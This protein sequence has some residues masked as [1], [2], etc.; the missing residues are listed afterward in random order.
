MQVEEMTT[1][2]VGSL[3]EEKKSLR[4]LI[5]QGVCTNTFWLASVSGELDLDFDGLRVAGLCF[6]ASLALLPH[7]HSFLGQNLPQ[8]FNQTQ[9]MALRP[10][11]A[12]YAP[13]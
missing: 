13:C 11:P 9:V 5:N 6:A 2:W 3:A 7:L 1:Q 10:G 8:S 4:G 12:E